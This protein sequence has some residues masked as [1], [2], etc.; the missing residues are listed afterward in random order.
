MESTASL[1]VLALPFYGIQSVWS[2]EMA[3]GVL[4]VLED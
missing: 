1:L 3:F 2:T 4:P